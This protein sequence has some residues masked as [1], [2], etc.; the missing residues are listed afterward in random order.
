LA[1]R[2]RLKRP[3]EEAPREPGLSPA[4]R[5]VLGLAAAGLFVLAGCLLFPSAVWDRFVYRYFWGST[6]ADALG[7][8]VN[9]VTEDYNLI[10][11]V[12]YGI[13][14]AAAEIGRAHV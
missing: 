7:H 5:L 14:L 11:T 3:I 13:M 4:R 10:S 6:E 8:S 2:K 9:G 1:E 12:V